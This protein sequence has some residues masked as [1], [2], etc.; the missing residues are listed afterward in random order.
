MNCPDHVN[1]LPIFQNPLVTIRTLFHLLDVNLKTLSFTTF[2]LAAAS[3]SADAFFRAGFGIHKEY[4]QFSPDAPTFRSGSANLY[5]EDG[6]A[7]QTRCSYNGS[8]TPFSIMTPFGCNI[9]SNAVAFVGSGA[10]VPYFFEL[11]GVEAATT[12]EPGRHD[13]VSLYARPTYDFPLNNLIQSVSTSIF[14]NLLTT[15]GDIREYRLASSG[16]GSPGYSFNRNYGVGDRDRMER[17]IVTGVYQFRFP[18]LGRPNSPLYLNFPVRPTVEGYVRRP[19]PGGFRFTNVGPYDADRFAQ[20]DMNVISQF[21]WEGLDQGGVS[22][23]DRLYIGFRRIDTPTD[24][25]TTLANNSFGEPIYDFPP[26]TADPDIH[27]GVRIYLPSPVQNFYNL[28]AGFFAAGSKT[29]LEL[30]LERDPRIGLSAVSTRKFQL[31]IHFVN[32][33]ASIAAAFPKDTDPALLAKNADPDG[34]GIPNW[35]EWVS[36]TDPSKP[37]PPV[38]LSEIAFVPESVR[39]SGQV[40]PGYWFMSVPRAPNLPKGVGAIVE[41]STDL[42]EWKKIEDD[43]PNWMIEDITSEPQVR[44]IS[45]TPE[46]P[47]SS[48]FRVRYTDSGSL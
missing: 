21:R 9:G 48:T 16:F 37:N 45:R 44:V 7:T 43:D 24:A 15:T 8:T 35:L 25:D 30:T 10:P 29:M 2:T 13:L 4:R 36:G 28:P 41:H 34:D 40:V 26:A 14:Y 12:I 38:G 17:E 27:P 47:P 23:G 33:P 42:Q 6:V 1:T 39:R 19:I 3:L 22:S 5:V 11:V 18:P 31:P 20:Y 32:G 46:I